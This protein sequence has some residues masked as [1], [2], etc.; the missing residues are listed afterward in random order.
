MD[1]EDDIPENV[2]VVLEHFWNDS[3]EEN[4]GSVNQHTFDTFVEIVLDNCSEFTWVTTHDLE[5]FFKEL[6]QKY[7]QLNIDTWGTIRHIMT[8]CR[9]LRHE[10]RMKF[11]QSRWK[12]YENN[13]GSVDD[14]QSSMDYL[15]M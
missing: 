7:A 1:T 11:L 8:K 12:Q 13:S 10:Q 14:V 5:Q 4:K 15:Y 9:T 6:G 3:I 2:Y